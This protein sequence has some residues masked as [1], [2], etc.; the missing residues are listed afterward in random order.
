MLVALSAGCNRSIPAPEPESEPVVIQPFLPV[1]PDR[2][3]HDTE[4]RSHSP[5]EAVP[6]PIDEPALEPALTVEAVVLEH[7]IEDGSSPAEPLVQAVP[8]PDPAGADDLPEGT[9]DNHPVEVPATEPK[10][11]SVVAVL[12][13]TAVEPAQTVTAARPALE[14]NHEVD[15]LVLF[16]DRTPR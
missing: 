7:P 11:Q 9:E 15:L 3:V 8:E 16:T 6:D 4:Q 1:S 10:T 5:V 2:T 13:A 14:R 12:P